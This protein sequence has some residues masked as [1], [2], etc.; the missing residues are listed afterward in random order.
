MSSETYTRRPS[1]GKASKNGDAKPP[2]T[3][4]VIRPGELV[5]AGSIHDP[6]PATVLEIVIAAGSQVAYRVRWFAGGNSLGIP[7]RAGRL[8][9]GR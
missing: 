6:L 3:L 5:E 7:C 2:A 4:H 8:N 9:L 1:R